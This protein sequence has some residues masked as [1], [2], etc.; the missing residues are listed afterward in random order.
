MLKRSALCMAVWAAGPAA[1]FGALT[2]VGAQTSADSTTPAAIEQPAAAVA[3]APVDPLLALVRQQL[4][5]AARANA[6]RATL[7]AFY[8]ERSGPLLWVDQG[9]LTSRAREV[10]AELAKAEDWGLPAAA[11]EVPRLAA[12]ADAAALA[13]AEIKLGL[14]V[15][16]YARFARG[17]RIDPAHVSPNFDQRPPL[18]DPKV[19]LEAMASSETPSAYLR[20]LNPQHPQFERLRHA[21][22]KARTG[23]AAPP[24]KTSADVKLPDGPLLKLGMQHADVALL[25]RRLELPQPPGA[26]TIYDMQVRDAVRAFQK[27]NGIEPSGNL[28]SR[29]RSAL[30]GSQ[31]PSVAAGGEVERLLVNME[32]WRWMPEELGD[33]YVWDNV[34]EF[35]TRVVKA[36]EVIH[37]AKIV[38][39]KVDN[40]TP[41]FSANMRY[42][43]FHPEWGVPDSIK[44]KEIAPYLRPTFGGGDF[45]SFFSGGADTRVLERHN[46]KVSYNGRPVDASQV[47]WSAVDIRRFTFIQPAGPTNVLGAVKFRFPNKHDVYMHDTPQRDLFRYSS[48]TFSHGCMRVENPGRLAEILLARDKGWS[49]E[50]VRGL[51]AEGYNNEVELTTQI[52]VHVTYFTAVVGDD[53]RVAYFADVYG[54]DARTA[55]ALAGKPL[56]PLLVA[57]DGEEPVKQLRRARR[58]AP[59]DDIW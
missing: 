22:L 6:D 51:L 48:R 3:A 28:T 44:L 20:R 18:R 23:H 10:M 43:V 42:V 37:S 26:E 54:H 1:L 13:G 19:V 33:F 29:T 52:P 58:H 55:A 57:N 27:E 35:T 36:G 46:L 30:N 50:K 17:G 5:E 9:G 11:F 49:A 47:N 45:F 2:P 25:R 8:T 7:A 56:A 15:L 39:G 32:R 38:V 14:A 34:P 16:K 59:S 12:G 21:L 40:Q 31:R 53:G 41:L 4:G 24:A